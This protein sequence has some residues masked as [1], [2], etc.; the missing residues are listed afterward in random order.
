MQTLIPGFE[1][2]L[3]G[4]KVGGRRPDHRP[5]QPRLWAVRREGPE[6]QPHRPRQQRPRVQRGP[7]RRRRHH[8]AVADFEPS[9]LALAPPE[10][11]RRARRRRC[12]A[13]PCPG[14]PASSVLRPSTRPTVY[15]YVYY[16]AEKMPGAMEMQRFAHPIHVGIVSASDH[17]AAYSAVLEDLRPTFADAPQHLE[18]RFEVVTPPQQ[19]YRRVAPRQADRHRHHL[20]VGGLTTC[21]SLTPSPANSN[22]RRRSRAAWLRAF[23][24]RRR[25]GSRTPSR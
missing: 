17:E 8:H 21:R 6:Q 23:P 24:M 12:P 3:Q 7:R 5:A 19:R 20:H 18:V 11:Y 22:T 9:V 1:I 4:M 15:T 25:R 2:G 13:A 14:D 16:I 10:G